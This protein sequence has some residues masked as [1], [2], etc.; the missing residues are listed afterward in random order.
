MTTEQMPPLP[1]Y[2]YGAE[3]GDSEKCWME[4]DLYEYARAYAAQEVAREREACAKV[5]DAHF[6]A[7]VTSG[8]P[9]EASTA[10]ALAAAIR[11]RNA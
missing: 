3:A 1:P 6:D 9:R 7:R 10:R 4:R 5:C 2:F 8:H 11:A